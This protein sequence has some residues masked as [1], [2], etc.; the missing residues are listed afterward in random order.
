M[1]KK[2]LFFT[3]ALVVITFFGCK[4]PKEFIDNLDVSVNPLEMHANKVEVTVEGSFPDK[5]FTKKMTMVV[6]PVLKTKEGKEYKAAPKTY[7]G[8]KV[9]GNNQTIKYKVGGKY[10]QTA[11]FDYKEGME[12]SELF[13]NVVVISGNKE[14]N[15]DPVKVADG[16]NITPLL[17]SVKPGTG[18]LNAEIAPDKFQRIIEE[19]EE[20]EILFLINQSQVRYN[21]MRGDDVVALTKAIKDAKADDNK[22]IKGLSISSYASPEGD[23]DLNEKLSD[24]RGNASS[25]YI[26]R[27]IKRLRAEVKIDSKFTAE[28]W[29]GFKALIEASSIE[30]KAVILRVLSMYSDSEQREKEIKNISAAYKVIADDILPKLRRSKMELTVN[31]IGK[32]DEEISKLAKEDPKALNLE[33]ILYSATLVN[34]LEEKA[35]IYSKAIELFPNCSRAKNNLGMVRYEQMNITEADRYFTE[36]LKINAQSPIINYNNGLVA[37][38]KGNFKN[39]EVFF[40]KAGGVGNGLNYANAVLAIKK[41]Q[42]KKAV[43]LLGA[44]KSNNAVLANILNKNNTAARNVAAEIENSNATTYYLNAIICARTNDANG[45]VDNLQKAI[46]GNAEYKGKAAD[47]IEFKNMKENSEFNAL[48]K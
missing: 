10:K 4:P 7:Q 24:R 40:G 27:Q 25:R 44:S 42:Y 14:Y 33:E 11:V 45:V 35:V 29:D 34:T 48:V 9:K 3:I 2:T 18:D 13:M 30:D 6:T 21:E 36:A 19:K 26:E 16:V 37:L 5:Y 22:E 23:L 41:G 8:E 12:V 31:V 46:N 20:A 38:A 47:D 32:S 17:V 39:A 43:S 1:K 28:D 15:L